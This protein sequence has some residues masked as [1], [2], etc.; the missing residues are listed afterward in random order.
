[1]AA[2]KSSVCFGYAEPFT[3]KTESLSTIA[4]RN[5]NEIQIFIR[6][7]YCENKPD[8]TGL[9][10]LPVDLNGRTTLAIVPLKVLKETQPVKMIGRNLPGQRFVPEQVVSCMQDD[11]FTP[12]EALLPCILNS[13]KFFNVMSIAGNMKTVVEKT[14]QYAKQREQFG[15]PIGKFQAIA[16]MLVDMK[17]DLDSTIL[18]GHWLAWH[19]DQRDGNAAELTREANLANIFASTA[20]ANAVNTSI[21]VMGGYGYMKESH[22]ERY[23]RDARMTCF[24]PEEGY[25]Q[26]MAV[27]RQFNMVS[28]V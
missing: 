10:F 22:M 25:A 23:A 13:L 28:M 8:R 3:M 26:K 17:I 16:H 2:G 20:Y 11:L 18:Y 6:P 4:S 1:L 24:F 5:E 19:L 15:Q 27:A 14:I 7:T 21:Q 9:L 12:H